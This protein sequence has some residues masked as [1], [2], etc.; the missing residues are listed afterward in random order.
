LMIV[1]ARAGSCRKQ[2]NSHGSTNRDEHATRLSRPGRAPWGRTTY[3][4]LFAEP[5]PL[6][7]GVRPGRSWLRRFW[8]RGQRRGRRNG[9][10]PIDA[11]TRSG[12]TDR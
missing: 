9:T 4:R 11:G 7:K 3:R 10:A 1:L 5:D 12:G 2:P 6:G 8:R